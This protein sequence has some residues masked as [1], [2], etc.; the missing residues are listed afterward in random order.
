MSLF[1]VNAFWEIYM[2]CPLVI[3]LLLRK[4]VLCQNVTWTIIY[5]AP[6]KTFISNFIKEFIY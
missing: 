4:C 2:L 1:V 5:L 6:F 3:Y